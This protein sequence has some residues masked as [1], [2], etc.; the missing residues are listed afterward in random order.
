MITATNITITV[1]RRALARRRM[2]PTNTTIIIADLNSFKLLPGAAKRPPRHMKIGLPVPELV[3]TIG[4]LR[5]IK[6]GE[7]LLQERKEIP[8][9][10]EDNVI[11]ARKEEEN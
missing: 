11:A 5:M 9:E 1:T 7:T 6:D 2:T 4:G 8:R 3:L 10:I